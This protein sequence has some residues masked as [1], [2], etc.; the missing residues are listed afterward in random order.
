MSLPVPHHPPP[1][2][3][4]ADG[5]LP[6]LPKDRERTGRGQGCEAPAAAMPPHPAVVGVLRTPSSKGLITEAIAEMA[7]ATKFLQLLS[8]RISAG[9]IP[10]ERDAGEVSPAAY[11]AIRDTSS[12]LQRQCGQVMAVMSATRA[13]HAV[14]IAMH[15]HAVAA[16]RYERAD[17]R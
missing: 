12:M 9:K 5:T 13:H 11:A 6:L 4:Q 7:A 1:S 15:A 8:E 14:H 2:P 3:S 17:G 10:G 16:D